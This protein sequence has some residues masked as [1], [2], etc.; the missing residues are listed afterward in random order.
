MHAPGTITRVSPHPDCPSCHPRSSRLTKLFKPKRPECAV[1]APYDASL[2]PATLASSL[3]DRLDAQ[4]AARIS[5]ERDAPRPMLIA[6]L[7]SAGCAPHL[8]RVAHTIRDPAVRPACSG[9]SSAFVA[10]RSARDVDEALVL[11]QYRAAA[12]L[13]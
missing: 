6:C 7:P 2:A 5:F 10:I 11:D 4:D 8:A 12:G 13:P 1:C 3:C 9:Y